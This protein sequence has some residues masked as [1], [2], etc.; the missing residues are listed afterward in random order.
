MAGTQ[1]RASQGP[2]YGYTGAQPMAGK[3]G[4]SELQANS[5]GPHRGPATGYEKP[6]RYTGVQLGAIQRPCQ[7]YTGRQPAGAQ[8]GATLGSN[9]TESQSRSQGPLGYTGTH[10][11]VHRAHPVSRQPAKGYTGAQLGSAV[12]RG[13]GRGYKGQ[14]LHVAQLGAA[15]GPSQR[16]TQAPSPRN[17]E[18]PE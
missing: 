16:Y 10:P 12:H 9:Y 13:P 5:Y 17:W 1:L 4:P 8:P 2:S 14:M 6:C 15:Q 18:Q 11:V 3:Q 7:V